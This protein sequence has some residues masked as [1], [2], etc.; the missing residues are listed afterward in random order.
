MGWEKKNITLADRT[1]V[2]D[3]CGNVIDRDL[4]AAL[5]LENTVKRTGIYACGDCVSPDPIQAV[6]A[7]AG[8]N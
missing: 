4:N 2:C 8:T 1:F 3:Q 7:E 6:I 5:N